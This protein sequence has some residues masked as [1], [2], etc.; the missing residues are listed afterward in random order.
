MP[1]LGRCTYLI[2]DLVFAEMLLQL[3]LSGK[4]LRAYCAL[5]VLEL[6]IAE[7]LCLTVTGISI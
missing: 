6:S 3:A 7:T 2:V 4:D 1:T 5:L